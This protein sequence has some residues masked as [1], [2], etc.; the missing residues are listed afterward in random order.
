MSA[1]RSLGTLWQ[2]LRFGARL[3][4]H[5]R[6]FAAVS[7]LILALGI[8]ACTAIFSVLYAASYSPLPYKNPDRLVVLL[9]SESVT[10]T[11]Q[12]RPTVGALPS[13]MVSG[14][15]F[16]QWQKQSDVFSALA[17]AE[18]FGGEVEA[19]GQKAQIE[20]YEVTPD[21]FKV[22]DGKAAAGRLLNAGDDQPGQDHVVVLGPGF[23]QR[24]S[25]TS[26]IEV[27]GTLT[28]NKQEYAV[29]GSLPPSYRV[30]NA[31]EPLMFSQ[32]D[33]FL[34]IPIAQ[35]E[36]AAP[37]GR[38][39]P[40]TFTAIG[41][42]KPNAGIAQAQAEMT[43]VAAGLAKANPALDAGVTVQVKSMKSQVGQV[44]GVVLKLLLA[45]V[46]FLLLL[47]CVNI[48]VLTLTQG[49]RRQHELAIRHAVGATRGRIVGQLF[50]ES[51][52]LALAGGAC[53]IE[54]AF[55][56]EN[57]LV[58]RI[59]ARALPLIAPPEINWPVLAFALA[60]SV[61]AAIL[62]GVIPAL[63]LSLIPS[64]ELL[65]EAA[66]G[67]GAGARSGWLRNGFVVC[68]VTLAFALLIVCGLLIG[69]VRGVLRAAAGYNPKRMMRMDVALAPATYP[70]FASRENAYRQML[71]GVERSPLVE[72][73]GLATTV[74]IGIVAAADKPLTALAFKAGPQTI[75]LYVSP[76]YFHTHRLLRGR[77]F[78]W[79]DYSEKPAVAMVS[80]VL[81]D[82]LWPHQDPIGKHI[83]STYPA[84]PLE[85]IG[86]AANEATGAAAAFSIPQAYVPDL[87][88][89]MG[90]EVQTKGEAKGALALVHDLAAGAGPGVQVSAPMTM[91]QVL[92]QTSKPAENV[93]L[94][95]AFFGLM[96]LLLATVG[97]FAV[98]AY[99]VTQRTHE[100]GVRVALGARPAEILFGAMREGVR[101]S[102]YGVGFGL[103]VALALGKILM[104]FLF[105]I[106]FGDLSTYFG[107]ALLLMAVAVLASYFAAR[108]AARIDPMAALRSE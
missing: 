67:G 2:D 14:P 91:E 43:T 33:V 72:S 101:L 22:L 40:Y 8:G 107:V 10:G 80:Q 96:A 19:G 30:A 108:R 15:D 63:Q 103:L 28:L 74:T 66:H 76:G 20:G 48:A 105:G 12:G 17:A 86:V 16:L 84:E 95:L 11:F 21:F 75:T 54:V 42:L 98:T 68:E 49:A 78:T 34:P 89:G 60:V 65:K 94:V 73:A 24:G 47:A 52:L 37:P 9:R 45:A 1:M 83:T 46:G 70:S 18:W 61:A 104:H 36:K 102:L 27:G 82:D 88:S 92:A 38:A 69:N 56:M 58:S 53:G 64:A 29:I 23:A 57:G 31:S 100:I 81:A 13:P 5:N 79:S 32:P 87:S 3:L 50:S 25:W 99:A 39:M 97:V 62:F 6:R 77:A 26:A 44:P 51:L 7:I 41:R 106:G 71:A 59:P 55:W 93:Q 90:L 35:L 85:V 4:A